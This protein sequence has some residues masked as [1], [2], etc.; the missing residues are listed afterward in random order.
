MKNITREQLRSEVQK[1]FSENNLHYEFDIDCI[2][3]VHVF[4]EDGDWK[5]DHLRLK[6]IMNINDYLCLD[7]NNL[8]AEDD[9]DDSYSAEYIFMKM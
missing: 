9:G 7:T 1:L 4:V 6:H 3:H 2:N 5:H 8:D